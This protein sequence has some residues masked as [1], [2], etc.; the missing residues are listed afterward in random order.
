VRDARDESALLELDHVSAFCT[1]Q[2]AV[3]RRAASVIALRY[4][5]QEKE[6]SS[7]TK[8]ANWR[9]CRT[10]TLLGRWI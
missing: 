10:W 8:D 5:R 4:R 7:W 1:P 2:L 3:K 9:W 6:I